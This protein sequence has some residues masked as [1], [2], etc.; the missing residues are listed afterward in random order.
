MS[1]MVLFLLSFL[2]TDTSFHLF[3]SVSNPLSLFLS[4]SLPLLG[5][6]LLPHGNLQKSFIFYF[7]FIWTFRWSHAWLLWSPFLNLSLFYFIF[8]SFYSFC[9][10]WMCFFYNPLFKDL[11]IAAPPLTH[12][13]E[14][15][16]CGVYNDISPTLSWRFSSA[17]ELCLSSSFPS[18]SLQLPLTLVYG[19]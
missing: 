16:R 17:Y 8:L 15:F 12:Q 18:S 5:Y 7:L 9:I 6:Y 13:R 2:C 4:L 3:K 10:V 11:M 14:A 1:P 19:L